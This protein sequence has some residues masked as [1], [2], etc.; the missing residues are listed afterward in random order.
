MSPLALVVM[1]AVHDSNSAAVVFVDG[2]SFD[3]GKK[4]CPRILAQSTAVGCVSS[5]KVSYPVGEHRPFRVVSADVAIVILSISA[6]FWKSIYIFVSDPIGGALFS[7][8]P[9]WIVT[10]VR[11][12]CI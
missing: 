12:T 8:G 5:R 3:D 6:P 7:P 9:C 1:A 4:A 10:L 2:T 11:C